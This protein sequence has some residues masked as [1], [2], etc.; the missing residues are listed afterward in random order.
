MASALRSA[1][2]A[3][4]CSASFVSAAASAAR[5][6]DRSAHGFTSVVLEIANEFPHPGFDHRILRTPAGQVELLA[7][8][9][10]VA[11]G[12]L[13]ST[14]GIGDGRL[15][16]EVARAS[17]FL[18]IHFND[19]P[20][21]AIPARVRALGRFG[22]P[23]VCNEDDKLGRD[24]ARA[25]DLSVSNGA[26]WGLM[27]KQINQRYPFRFQGAADAPEI[28]AKIKRLTSP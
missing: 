1:A 20:L 17:D 9:K 3:S 4:S 7:L 10:K 26:S 22:K 8:A 12:L 25:A 11:P 21:A 27:L 18:L 23:I 13:V 5:A 6:A 15:P 14:S 2:V 24:G 16:D 28:Y 19:V